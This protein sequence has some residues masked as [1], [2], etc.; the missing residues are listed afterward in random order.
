MGRAESDPRDISLI[1]RL[2]N[3]TLDNKLAEMSGFKRVDAPEYGLSEPVIS[4]L[5]Y[6]INLRIGLEVELDLG[7]V[8]RRLK[9]FFLRE[10]FSDGNVKVLA[11]SSSLADARV[12]IVYSEGEALGEMTLCLLRT[13]SGYELLVSLHT[14]IHPDLSN[15]R[16]KGIEIKSTD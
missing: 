6:R 5:L 10:Y 4:D 8:I 15:Y 12:S 11:V 3:G 16:L 13:E 2:L 1:Q 9:A 7:L 14:Q